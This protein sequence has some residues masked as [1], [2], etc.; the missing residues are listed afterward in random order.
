MFSWCIVFPV[1]QEAV[2]SRDWE[3]QVVELLKHNE[4]PIE[5]WINTWVEQKKVFLFSIKVNRY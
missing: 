3:G 5:N 4:V 2:I 1:T